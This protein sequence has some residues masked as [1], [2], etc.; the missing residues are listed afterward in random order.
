MDNLNEYGEQ[1]DLANSESEIHQ[2][3]NRQ[4]AVFYAEHSYPPGSITTEQ[5]RRNMFN[6]PSIRNEFMWFLIAQLMK[7]ESKVD[8]PHQ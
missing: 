6:D 8:N 4:L 1:H 5:M 2:M 7:Y 3:M